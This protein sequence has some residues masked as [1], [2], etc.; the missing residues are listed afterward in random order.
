MMGKEL[1]PGMVIF[2]QPSGDKEACP[3]WYIVTSFDHE[4][5]RRHPEDGWWWNCRRL[6]DGLRQTVS[7]ESEHLQVGL[8]DAPQ[9]E[10]RGACEGKLELRKVG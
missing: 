7:E 6:C 4:Q 3:G 2:I 1:K 9:A 10:L 5:S 8:A